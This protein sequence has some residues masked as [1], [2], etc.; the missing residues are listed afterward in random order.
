MMKR[1]F[2]SLGCCRFKGYRKMTIHQEI[3]LVVQLID[4]GEFDKAYIVSSSIYQ[5]Y[6]DNNLLV[7]FTV[8]SLMIDIGHIG[9]NEEA[10]KLALEIMKEKEEKFL[11]MEEIDKNIFYYNFGNAKSNLIDNFK[12]LDISNNLSFNDIEDLIELKTYYWK[13]IKHCQEEGKIVPPE[14]IVNLGNSLKRQFRLVEAL[15]NYDNINH[16]KLD[17]PQSWINRS[18]T[19]NLLNQ[20]SNTYTISMLKEMRLGYENCILSNEIPKDWIDYYKNMINKIS[21]QIQETLDREQISDDEHD[22]INLKLEYSLLSEKRKFYLN[23]HLSLSEHGLYCKCN[24]SARDNLTIPT[25]NGITGEYIIPMEFVLNRL[26][27]EFIFAR[28]MYYEFVH[29]NNDKSIKYESCFSELHNDDIL[30][31]NIEKARTSFRVCFGVLD[32]IGVAVCDLYKLYPENKIVYF[33]NFWQL[34]NG[35]RRQ[36][37][38]DIKTPGLLALYSIA[39]DLNNRKDGELAF[40]KEWRNDLEHKFVVV[41]ENETVIDDYSTYSFFDNMLFIQESEL[42]ENLKILLQLTRSAIFSFVY[43]VREDS[44]KNKKKGIYGVR[45]IERQNI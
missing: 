16:L 5:E 24:G 44:L 40:F 25:L 23:N 13:A 8:A 17:I 22:K 36:K 15:T 35:N 7:L 11:A 32:K 1:L 19:L 42:I 18:E 45:K 31:I 3:N 4:Q 20:M 21:M 28:Q 2:G 10:S 27:S 14:Y 30:N 38:E 9:Q 26:K 37:F 33:Q 43:M 39:T 41:H 6:K 34:D 12:S 29:D